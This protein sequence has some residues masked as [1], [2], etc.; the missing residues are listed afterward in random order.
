MNILY[1]LTYDYSFKSWNDS[2]NLSR[3]L[4][5][6]NVF[7]LKYPNVNF[8][9]LSYGDSED[10]EYANFLDN[11]QIYP[12]YSYMKFSKNRLKRL[13]KS[14]LI[15]FVLYRKLKIENIQIIKQNQLQGVWVSIILKILLKVL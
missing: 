8:I 1:L 4:Q 3:E 13:L 11:S 15:P 6:F 7:K 9:F 5:Y 14:F 10:L 2:G 12:V